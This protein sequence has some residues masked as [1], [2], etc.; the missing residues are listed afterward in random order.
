MWISRCRSLK[1]RYVA[2]WLTSP[3]PCIRDF[4]P[5]GTSN[6]ICNFC[7]VRDPADHFIVHLSV[8]HASK[9]PATQPTGKTTPRTQRPPSRSLLA[10]A[11]TAVVRADPDADDSSTDISR[12][13]VNP[14]QFRCPDQSTE[15]ASRIEK[16]A[17]LALDAALSGSHPIIIPYQNNRTS[18][19]SL[20]RDTR[21]NS[22]R[23]SQSEPIVRFPSRQHGHNRKFSMRHL[24]L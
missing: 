8:M 9:M 24:N 22:Q 1:S 6:A 14:P 16:I 19:R 15:L 13:V 7:P 17:E 20:S 12:I 21:D 18:G 5:A 11:V 10:P 4:C 3:S 23:A 2:S